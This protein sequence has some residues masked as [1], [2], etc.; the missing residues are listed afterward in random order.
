MRIAGACLSR[1]GGSA[2]LED[3]R[4][5]F[6][7]DGRRA[8]AS[9]LGL[10]A[11]GIDLLYH[12]GARAGATANVRMRGSFIRMDLMVCGF[13]FEERVTPVQPEVSSR[14]TAD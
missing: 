2:L 10:E 3:A 7:R 1:I 8:D 14:L 11:A 13:V 6:V 12:G 4:Q 9:H 5:H